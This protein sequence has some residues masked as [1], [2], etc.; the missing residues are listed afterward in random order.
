MRT[1]AVVGTGLIGTS[2]A[3]ALRRHGV[4]VHLLDRDPETARDAEALGA[5]TAAAPRVPVDLAVLA[6]PPGTVA[7]V[8]DAQQ[9]AGLAHSYT[10]VASVKGAPLKAARD[11]G[12][13]LTR[14]IGGHPM[15]GRELSGPLAA[16]ADLFDGCTW[17]LTPSPAAGERAEAAARTLVGLCGGRP[18]VMR[19]DDHDRAVGLTSHV[20][21]L[22]AS[23]LAG[24]LVGSDPAHLP[25]VG[26]GFK[27]T[28]RVA[29]GSPALWADILRANAPAVNGVLS[30]LAAELGLA[31]RVLNELIR[32]EDEAALAELTAL[33]ARGVEGRAR[34][35]GSSESSGPSGS[36]GRQEGRVGAGSGR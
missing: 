27:D 31:Q 14:F 35:S 23:L 30:E 17:I 4:A 32:T 26:K 34:L 33:L 13:D 3:L 11:L 5:G 28:T 8:L 19:D 6:T 24:R 10:D 16:R 29:D 15:A 2:V 9:R 20:P 1:A 25:L 22:V 18:L 12:C 7:A 36:S 21:H